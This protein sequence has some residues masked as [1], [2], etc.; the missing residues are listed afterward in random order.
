MD[1]FRLQKYQPFLKYQSRY[2]IFSRFTCIKIENERS[3]VCFKTKFNFKNFE[4]E[5]T[6]QRSYP[7]IADVER[8]TFWHQR[9]KLSA[10]GCCVDEGVFETLSG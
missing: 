8:S 3:A 10:V 4:F 5:Y 9:A 1:I 7:V 6:K 2:V